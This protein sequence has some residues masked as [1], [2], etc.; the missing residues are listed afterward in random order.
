MN[1][2]GR[3]TAPLA[4]SNPARASN[5]TDRCETRVSQR[6]NRIAVHRQHNTPTVQPPLEPWPPARRFS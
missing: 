4:A 6:A 1:W 3:S 5:L 2:A